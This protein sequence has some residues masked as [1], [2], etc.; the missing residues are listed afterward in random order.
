MVLGMALAGPVLA[1]DG[2]DPLASFLETN[3]VLVDRALAFQG[4]TEGFLKAL[5]PDAR[6]CSA[7]EAAALRADGMGMSGA[8]TGVVA[9]VS[10]L[11]TLDSVELWPEEIAY[12]KVRG[13]R[14][15]SGAELLAHL[16]GLS[17]TSGVIVD[18]R[19][20]DGFDL[21]SVVDLA[22]PCHCP[23]DPLFTLQDTRG[24]TVAT[25]PAD[26]QDP[27]KAVILV[28]TDRDTRGAAETLAALW[29]GC[30]GIMLI[31]TATRGDSRVREILTLPDGRLLVIVSRRVVPVAAAD[32]ER[33][34]VAPDLTVVAMAGGATGEDVR[35]SA[36]PLS[37]KSTRD[38]ELMLR[39]DGDTVLRRATDILL[40]LR[41]LNGYGY[42]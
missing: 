23:G 12:L 39:V 37:E 14:Q 21:R 40:G 29:R 4:A 33:K 35:L 24:V 3:G 17:S 36:K 16:K 13:F 2:L 38:R 10:T 11:P 18:L 34:G 5:D 9:A 1:T 25:L 30:P 28:L 8:A 20:A 15:G 32:Y 41:A 6:F 27:P 19:G 22:S 31:G 7:E 26:D 42:R